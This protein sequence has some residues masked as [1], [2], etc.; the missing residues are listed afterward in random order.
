MNN[1]IVSTTNNIEGRNIVR[2]HGIVPVKRSWEPTFS[3]ISLPEF[4]TL[5][6]AGLALMRNLYARREKLRLMS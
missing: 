6:V 5:L 1:I 2:Y 3:K 4:A